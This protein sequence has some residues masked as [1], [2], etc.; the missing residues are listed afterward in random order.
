MPKEELVASRPFLK[1]PVEL[2]ELAG[3]SLTQIVLVVSH[4]SFAGIREDCDNGLTQFD[5]LR[6]SAKVYRVLPLSPAKH[7]QIT[8]Q[9]ST[10]ISSYQYYGRM[11]G[12]LDQPVDPEVPFLNRGFVRRE[13]AV[14]HKEV[15]AGTDGIRDKPFQAL[16]GVGEVAV[17]IE[18]KITGVSES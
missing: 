18:V 1:A 12:H 16:R 6:L 9:L 4:F 3:K 7:I 14:D 2:I 5:K 15:N 13:V 17:F 10:V 8:L 11:V